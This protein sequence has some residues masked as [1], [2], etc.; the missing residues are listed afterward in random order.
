MLAGPLVSTCIEVVRRPS[1][2][3][4]R[5]TLREA[6]RIL[7]ERPCRVSEGSSWVLAYCEDQVLVEASLER[8]RGLMEGM[9]TLAI[10]VRISGSPL[11]VYEVASLILKGLREN[12]IPAELLPGCTRTL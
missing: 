12:G 4:V 2:E 10:L 8:P 7:R 9:P 11:G 1:L 6:S 5:L 3:D